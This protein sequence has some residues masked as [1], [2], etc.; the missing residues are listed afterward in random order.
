MDLES[1][2]AT[3]VFPK[4]VAGAAAIASSSELSSVVVLNVQA[5]SS[6]TRILVISLSGHSAAPLCGPLCA[7]ARDYVSIAAATLQI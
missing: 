5:N 7:E 2:S 1:N 6:S 3:I 4:R